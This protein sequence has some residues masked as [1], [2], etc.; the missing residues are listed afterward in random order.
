MIVHLTDLGCRADIKN[1]VE[2]SLQ[3]TSGQSVYAREGGH[4][5]YISS[6]RERSQI[7]GLRHTTCSCHRPMHASGLSDRVLGSAVPPFDAFHLVSLPHTSSAINS[8]LPAL[9]VL[10]DQ[11][12]RTA[13]FE[14]A[15]SRCSR[16]QSCLLYYRT[17]L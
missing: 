8:V 14:P 15:P 11:K 13:G 16:H 3:S 10:E 9:E 12:P 5:I 2:G 1:P 6:T 4:P 17:E 7:R